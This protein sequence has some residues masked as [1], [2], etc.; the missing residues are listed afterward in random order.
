[1]DARTKDLVVKGSISNFRGRIHARHAVQANFGG[2]CQL[3]G[4]HGGSLGEKVGARTLDQRF[5]RFTKT[6]LVCDDCLDDMSSI[7]RAVHEEQA[8]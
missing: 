8:P 1:M 2:W 6:N 4:Q 3:C 5:V 7:M